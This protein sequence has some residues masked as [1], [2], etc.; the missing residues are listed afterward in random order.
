[1]P[2]QP[3]TPILAIAARIHILYELHWYTYLFFLLW[4]SVVLVHHLV[5]SCRHSLLDVTSDPLGGA[6]TLP[7]GGST[8]VQPP[9]G[10][11]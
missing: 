8:R 10:G 3:F 7:D 4:V 6:A 1:M 9:Q 11:S 5:H 2:F